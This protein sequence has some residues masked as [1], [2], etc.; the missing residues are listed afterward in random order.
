MNDTNNEKVVLYVGDA[1]MIQNKLPKSSG[2]AFR[3]TGK[4]FPRIGLEV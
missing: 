1:K 3:S 2:F 4:P